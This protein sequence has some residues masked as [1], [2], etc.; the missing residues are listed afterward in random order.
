MKRLLLGMVLG[1]TI[2][3]PTVAAQSELSESDQAA[4]EAAVVA[5]VAI[6]NYE[7]YVEVTRY[8]EIQE[9]TVT[10]AGEVVL[11]STRI[12]EVESR[13]VVIRG[14]DLPGEG[15]YAATIFTDLD[16]EVDYTIG[17]L[18]YVDGQLYG[19][20]EHLLPDGTNAPELEW[21]RIENPEDANLDDITVL[22]PLRL[23]LN[24]QGDYASPFTNLALM[25]DLVRDVSQ[26]REI[27]DGEVVD[28][29]E[30]FF[31]PGSL[32]ELIA[33]LPANLSEG[34]EINLLYD[35]MFEASSASL[36]LFVDQD[37]Q[38]RQLILRINSDAFGVDMNKVDPDMPAGF[39]ADVTLVGEQ[40]ST[41][42]DINT[43]E[44]SIAPPA[45]RQ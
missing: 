18:R 21:V 27:L 12:G 2:W 43:V 16:G 25:Q 11:E 31:R 10:S 4:L 39:I 19:A 44:E 1:L 34:N 7:S 6:G 14:G 17:E 42:S 33:A 22:N 45:I 5:I 24:V 8:A 32:R 28:V 15:Q 36:A 23:L 30:L 38:L 35:F 41:F 9:M 13:T 29:T 40:V 20:A 3:L 26:R 37:N